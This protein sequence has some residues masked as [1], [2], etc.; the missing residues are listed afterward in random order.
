MCKETIYFWINFQTAFFS[1][2][3]KPGRDSSVIVNFVNCVYNLFKFKLQYTS[4]C[5]DFVTHKLLT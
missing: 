1:A 5:E 3:T 4:H 2:L